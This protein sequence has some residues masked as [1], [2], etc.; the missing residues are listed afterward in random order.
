MDVASLVVELEAHGHLALAREFEKQY[1]SIREKAYNKALYRFYLTVNALSRAQNIISSSSGSERDAIA[2]Y[3]SLICR[4]L[5]DLRKPF[6]I[7]ITGAQAKDLG[8][9]ISELIPVEFFSADIVSGSS[10][11]YQEPSLITFEKLLSATEDAVRAGRSV[12]LVWPFKRE[13]EKLQLTKLFHSLGVAHLFVQSVLSKEEQTRR[14]LESGQEFRFRFSRASFVD[15]LPGS[16]GI[17]MKSLV[18]EPVLASPDLVLYVLRELS[19]AQTRSLGAP[20][21]DIRI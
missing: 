10:G 14:A 21:A 3:L 18:L 7:A 6:V 5:L 19:L 9:N 15:Q 16:V 2:V 17:C 12:V 11:G 13:E 8:Q 1:F 20:R 4:Y